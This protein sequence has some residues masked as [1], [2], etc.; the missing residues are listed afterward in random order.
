[1]D[2]DQTRG[3]LGYLSTR[4]PAVRRLSLQMTDRH[5]DAIAQVLGAEP[6]GPAP[7]IAKIHAIAL[8][9]VIQTITDLAGQGTAAG[10]PST[11]IANEL[12]PI[13]L[14]MID[15]LEAWPALQRRGVPT[16]AT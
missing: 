5:A 7:A 13:V 6:G 1:M 14:A 8:A 3:G 16:H 12:R 2:A 10:Q 9:W 15:E 4:S 11:Q